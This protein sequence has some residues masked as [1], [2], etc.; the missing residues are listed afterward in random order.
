MSEFSTFRDAV[1]ARFYQITALA[2]GKCERVMVVRELMFDG[3]Q[4]LDL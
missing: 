2:Q 1:K 3:A 4:L